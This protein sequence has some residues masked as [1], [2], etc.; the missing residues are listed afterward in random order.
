MTKFYK[1]ND[2]IV[3]AVELQ[4]TKTRPTSFY[5]KPNLL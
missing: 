1:G 4:L 3:I 2:V 5:K